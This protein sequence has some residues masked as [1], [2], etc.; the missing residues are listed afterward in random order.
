MLKD[1]A[2]Q[3]YRYMYTRSAHN[4]A[5][6]LAKSMC[7]RQQPITPLIPGGSPKDLTNSQSYF[8]GRCGNTYTRQS[9]GWHI[10]TANTFYNVELEAG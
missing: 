10:R 4:I 7:E 6:A 8:T 9:C 2:S 5:Y 1:P 3:H